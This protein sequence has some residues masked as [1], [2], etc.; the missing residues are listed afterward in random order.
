[1]DI[2][3]VAP[4]Y[5]DDLAR[6][7]EDETTGLSEQLLIN[8]GAKFQITKLDHATPLFKLSDN[9]NA[10]ADPESISFSNLSAIDGQIYQTSWSKLLGTELIFDDYG[11]LVGTVREHLV[12]DPLVKVK[13]RPKDEKDD[14]MDLEE[15][16]EEADTRT[17]FLK[18]AIAAAKAK[19]T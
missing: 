9:S 14:L 3:I 7:R 19:A 10:A 1:M 12:S 5:Y 15:D 2:P 8:P 4:S 18:K 6:E 16:T 11:E 13:P 17:A